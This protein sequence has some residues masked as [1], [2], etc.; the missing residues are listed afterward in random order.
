MLIHFKCSDFSASI[1]FVNGLDSLDY[2]NETEKIYKNGKSFAP[3]THVSNY[4]VNFYNISHDL[5]SRKI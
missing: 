1:C 5:S 2:F 3:S 4:R